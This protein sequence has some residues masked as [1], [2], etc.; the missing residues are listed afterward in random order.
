MLPHCSFSLPCVAHGWSRDGANKRIGVNTLVSRS[1][2]RKLKSIMLKKKLSWRWPIPFFWLLI[3]GSWH[4]RKDKRE[5]CAG[6]INISKE[7]GAAW[8]W[9]VLKWYSNIC[10]IIF[11]WVPLTFNH[12]LAPSVQL[13]LM[14]TVYGLYW[15]LQNN[16]ITFSKAYTQ[17][18]MWKAFCTFTEEIFLGGVYT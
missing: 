4:Y 8:N 3:D 9:F 17:K 10:I 13:F 5:Y 18:W 15:S 12:I 7:G 14:A 2:V 11:S 16:R 1:W 6:Q